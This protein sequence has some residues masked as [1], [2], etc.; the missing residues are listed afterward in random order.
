MSLDTL[1]ENTRLKRLLKRYATSISLDLDKEKLTELEVTNLFQLILTEYVKGKVPVDDLSMFCEMVYGKLNVESDLFSLLL[2]GAEIEWY[3]RYEPQIAADAITDL[4]KTFKE[5][6]SE[7]DNS[8]LRMRKINDL[9]EKYY[10]WAD[11]DS[12]KKK[13]TLEEGEK[14]GVCLV[15]DYVNGK[16]SIDEL[17]LMCGQVYWKLDRNSDLYTIFKASKD[18]SQEIRKDP[19][20]ACITIEELFAYFD[21]TDQGDERSLI[22]NLVR[23]IKYNLFRFL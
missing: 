18:I 5:N 8:T 21:V 13:F 16:I 17:A 19:A 9:L 2:M 10:L 15:E 12:N 7:K 6:S 3:I 1:N 23:K 22:K 4:L 11:V 14:I 20:R